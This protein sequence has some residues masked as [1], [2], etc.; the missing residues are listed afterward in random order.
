MSWTQC[1]YFA[2]V[3]LKKI[4]NNSIVHNQNTAIEVLQLTFW[5]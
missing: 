5:Q 3:K 1:F 4:Y 2:E